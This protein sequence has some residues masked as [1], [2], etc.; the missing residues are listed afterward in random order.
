MKKQV[1]I[2]GWLFA[3]AS[4]ASAV[5]LDWSGTYRLEYMQ[6][7]RAY[8][9]SGR[10]AKSYVLQHLNLSPKLVPVD[11]YNIVA[12]FEIL[13]NPNYPASQVGQ[14][15]GAGQESSTNMQ[16]RE[17]YL[18]V[19]QEYG[20]IT[21]G[22]AP[23]QFG[24]GM[25]YNAGKGMFD[26]WEDV[27]DMVGYKFIVG[28]LSFMPAIGKPFEYSAAQG[29]KITELIADVDYTNPETESSFGVFYR[30]L[31]SSKESN[32]AYR[33]FDTTV[34][35]NYTA[36]SA[37]SGWSTTSTNV[38]LARGWDSFKFRMEAGFNSG[39]T[40]LKTSTGSDI[41]MNGYGI[42]LEMEFPTVESR[43]QWMVRAG[44]ASGDN[45]TTDN[46]E[47]FFMNRNYDMAFLLFN[48]PMGA[49]DVLTTNAQRNKDLRTTCA[50]PPCPRIPNEEAVDEETIS[51]AVY[52]SPKVDYIFSDRWDWRNV[53]TYAQTQ[54]NPS[55]TGASVANDL[56]YEWDTGLIYKPHERVQWLNEL[57]LFFPGGAFK[58]TAPNGAGF[59]WGFQSKAAIT[60]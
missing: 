45:P 42:A 29:N 56:G 24:L 4:S 55:R 32:A 47:G 13:G 8:L 15:F 22:R 34:N 35:P 38:Y 50:A 57:G 21:A 5:T 10:G 39:S 59:N 41:K 18:R 44:I 31:T 7:D 37:D 9:D 25:T 40:G 43:W 16:V 20:E 36:T 23:L 46:F 28:N 54:A 14:Y 12:N 17:L 26:H 52:L 33:D 51:N 1:L 27:H 2:V 60:F 48:H 3:L 58:D 30:I 6:M 19:D 49:T 53:F 11:G